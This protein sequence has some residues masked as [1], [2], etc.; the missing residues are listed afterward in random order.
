[1]KSKI[2]KLQPLI[3]HRDHEV[4][5]RPSKTAHHYAYYYCL[6]CQQHVSWVPKSQV[7]HAEALGLYDPK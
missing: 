4:E 6:D 2:I 5:I 1:M 7:K 3:R